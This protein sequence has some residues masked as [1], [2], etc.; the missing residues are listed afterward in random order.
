M[1]S[2][3]KLIVYL[4]LSFL[5]NSFFIINNVRAKDLINKVD[6]QIILGN[7]NHS[8]E[9]FEYNSSCSSDDSDI[10]IK[11]VADT[12]KKRNVM[13]TFEEEN[14]S[15]NIPA[16][17]KFAQFYSVG[18]DEFFFISNNNDLYWA[19]CAY[20]DGMDFGKGGLSLSY[21]TESLNEKFASLKD[22]E[23]SIYPLKIGKNKQIKAY[24]Y[25]W[26][27]TGCYV[28]Y[29]IPLKQ[30]YL[31]ISDILDTDPNNWSTEC[32]NPEKLK[33]VEDFTTNL[34]FNSLEIY[35]DE[36]QTNL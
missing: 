4:T 17:Y 7:D 21:E 22:F 36:N 18:Y 6:E 25:Y 27:E 1:N 23:V 28:N 29:L 33:G 11:D 30:G 12:Q 24:K 34:I 15:F 26:S 3:L 20:I 9:N 14:I 8:E 35:S 5:I 16:N 19:K 10:P 31:A 32:E 13:Y 2:K